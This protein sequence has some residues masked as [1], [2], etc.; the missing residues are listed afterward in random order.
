LEKNI[1]LL[2]YLCNSRRNLLPNI[3][4]IPLGVIEKNI[5]RRKSYE[6]ISILFHS[7]YFIILHDL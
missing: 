4:I 1:D 2:L 7:I 6:I 5:T 3:F